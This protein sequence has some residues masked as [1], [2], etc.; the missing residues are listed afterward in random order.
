M[1]RASERLYELKMGA[2]DHG[3]PAPRALPLA[4][5]AFMLF[6]EQRQEAMRRARE[7]SGLAAGWYGKNP[8]RLLRL[9][10][11]FELL[12]WA[13]HDDGAGEPTSVSADAVV[14][15]GGF[16]DYATEMFERVIA[17]LAITRAQADAS[18]V[19]RHVL[20][21]ARRAP[22]CARLKP[23]NERTL[24]QRHGF[25]WARDAKRR[26]EAFAVLQDA[27]WLRSVQPDGHGRPRGDWQVNPRI[28]E[29]GQ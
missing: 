12:A 26:A 24:Y 21:I 8:G 6:D 19:A 3:A 17:G 5:D 2:D 15:A 7:S 20:E 22:P 11:V 4:A 1:H 13:A 14:R 10:L 23:L 28:V 25:A 16:I 9:A 27:G 18:Q 29:S